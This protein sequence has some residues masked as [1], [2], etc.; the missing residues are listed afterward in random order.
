MKACVGVGTPCFLPSSTT[1]PDSHGSSM[2]LPRNRSTAIEGRSCGGTLRL[3][4]RVFSTAS[5][6][7]TTPMA[8]PTEATS[9]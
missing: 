4:F 6:G 5:A 8:R 1:L 7:R 2:R 3:K 9:S